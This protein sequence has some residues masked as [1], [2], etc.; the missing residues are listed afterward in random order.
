MAGDAPGMDRGPQ[1]QHRGSFGVV[2]RLERGAPRA[3]RIRTGITD[4]S[5][6]AAYSDSLQ[7]GDLLVVGTDR[8]SGDAS[9]PGT[10]NPFAPR[11]PGP[12]GGRR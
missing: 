1:E 3:V 9:Q 10:V 5:F 2:Y 8:G 11:F 6:T 4:G 7:E 12:G